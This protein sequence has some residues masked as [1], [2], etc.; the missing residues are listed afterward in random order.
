MAVSEVYKLEKARASLVAVQHEWQENEGQIFG[1]THSQM[2]MWVK[3]EDFY[4][5]F[6]L[7]T[8]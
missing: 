3:D 8:K 7:N 1:T 4:L 2:L 5:S 6:V